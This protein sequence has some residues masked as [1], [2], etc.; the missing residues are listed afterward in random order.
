MSEIHGAKNDFMG[1]GRLIPA[2]RINTCTRW[3]QVTV[4]VAEDRR[5]GGF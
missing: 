4:A 2:V 3:E 1:C 5:D